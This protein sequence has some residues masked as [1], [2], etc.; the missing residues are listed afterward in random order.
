[1]IGGNTLEFLP[2]TLITDLGLIALLL[3]LGTIL[4]AKVTI[5]QKI[6]LPASI[7]AGLLGL[8]FGPNGF[9]IIPFS[10]QI[11]TYPGILNAM[12]FGSLP[13]IS[14]RVNWKAISNRV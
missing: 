5:I 7:I 11:G 9:N 13:L 10:D 8:A 14:Q 4:R 2:W 12:I 3:L 1:M 6:F